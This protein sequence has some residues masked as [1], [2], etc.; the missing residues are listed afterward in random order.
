LDGGADLYEYIIEV[1]RLLAKDL[2]YSSQ[3]S[4]L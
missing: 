3:D 4:I 2:R 1:P